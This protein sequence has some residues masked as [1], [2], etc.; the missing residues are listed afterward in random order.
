MRQR[1]RYVVF[2]IAGGGREEILRVIKYLR[3]KV[4]E[5]PPLKLVEYNQKVGSGLLRCGHLQLPRLKAGISEIE[6]KMKISVIGVSGTIKKARKK[7]M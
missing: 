4:E 2:K 5:G 7:F 1:H 6:G 3:Q